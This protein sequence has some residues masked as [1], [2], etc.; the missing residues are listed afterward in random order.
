MRLSDATLLVIDVQKDFC[1]GGPLAVSEGDAIIPV[2]NRIAPLFGK[3]VA[4]G[5]WHP[6]GHISFASRHGK[7]V[8]ETVRFNGVD[9]KLWPDHCIANTRGAGFHSGL[10][11]SPINLILHKGLKR[12]LDSYS[13]FFENDR[14]TPTGLH[15]YL[16]GLNREE[17]YVCGLALDVCVFYTVMDAL[18]LGF[19]THL[20]E[21]AS[22]GI[23]D[24]EG[25]LESAVREMLHKGALGVRSEEILPS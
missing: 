22:R 5:D 17:L 16:R 7:K 19:S 2:I 23:D 6:E 9:Q 18:D 4:T 14:K 13:A 24:P 12:D 8:F 15:H 11:L 1:P 3:V 20:I 10:D 25:S 21:D